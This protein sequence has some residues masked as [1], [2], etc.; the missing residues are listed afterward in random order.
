MNV[1]KRHPIKSRGKVTMV[2]SEATDR[3]A[4]KLDELKRYKTAFGTHGGLMEQ[5]DGFA[6]RTYRCVACGAENVLPL[7]S[8]AYETR[9]PCKN[10]RVVTEQQRV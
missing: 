5:I 8:Q 4:E 1:N 6:V 7:R 2:A 10:C 3:S 9:G